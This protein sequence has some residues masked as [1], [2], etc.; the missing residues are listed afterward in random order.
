M[1]I[2]FSMNLT[3]FWL[4]KRASKPTVE[5]LGSCETG[6]GA[7]SKT[8]TGADDIGSTTVFDGSAIC[9]TALLRLSYCGRNLEDVENELELD[10]YDDSDDDDDE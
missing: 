8:S 6:V 5:I 9:S 7:S 1:K 10:C 3:W 4:G 2:S